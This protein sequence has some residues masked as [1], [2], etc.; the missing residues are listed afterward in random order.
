MLPSLSEEPF[1]GA[2][3]YSDAFPGLP[4]AHPRIYVRFRPQGVDP[5]LSLLGLVDTGAH[6]C[7]LNQGGTELVGNLLT[8][9]VGEMRLRTAYGTMQGTLYLHRIEFLAEVGDNIDIEVTVLSCPGWQGPCFL[10]YAGV[11][12]RLRFAVDPSKNHFKLSPL[13]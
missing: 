4:E 6:Y 12:D 7:I 10:G 9:N 8:E 13:S 2:S 3:E 1:A 11:L 5:G